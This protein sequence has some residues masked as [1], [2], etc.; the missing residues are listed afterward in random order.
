[1]KLSDFCE[2]GVS[3]PRINTMT[4][5]GEQFDRDGVLI[6]ENFIPHSL[7]DLYNECFNDFNKTEAEKTQGFGVGVPYMQIDEIKMLSLYRPFMDVLDS[8]FTDAGEMMMHLNLTGWRSTERNWHQDD[9]LNPPY[10]NGHYAGVWFALDD[11]DPAAGPFQ[12]VPGSHNALDV[13]RG[14]LIRAA[15]P[16]NQAHTPAWPKHAEDIL[17]DLYDAEIE[18]NNWEVKTWAGKKG[19]VLIWHGFLLHRGSKPIN[20]TLYRPTLITHYS[21]MTHRHD[22]H[23][24][25]KYIN[26]TTNS[27]GYYYDCR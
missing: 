1:M 2:A 4:A 18:K 7:I 3:K 25:A 8:L 23:A 13:C 16:H 26:H 14:E 11:I 5:Y 17:N 22:M 27:E 19:D 15:L 9:Y 6:L 10:V 20:P 21:S 24:R 12:Y